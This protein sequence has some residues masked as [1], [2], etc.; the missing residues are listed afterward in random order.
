MELFSH[1]SA[2][3]LLTSEETFVIPWTILSEP[4]ARNR[5]EF[6]RI[7]EPTQRA[8]TPFRKFAVLKLQS[9]VSAWLPNCGILWTRNTLLTMVR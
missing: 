7:M 9:E 6:V 3:I 1:A 8:T 2:K 5:I 4:V